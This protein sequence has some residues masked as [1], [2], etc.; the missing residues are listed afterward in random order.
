MKTIILNIAPR[1]ARSEIIDN[2]TDTIY[3]IVSSGHACIRQNVQNS[4]VESSV[5]AMYCH[6]LSALYECHAGTVY[7]CEHDVLYPIDWC[8]F[9][10][11]D[12]TLSYHGNGYIYQL[13]DG[14]MPRGNP[15]LSTLCG[16]RD[17]LIDAFTKNLSEYFTTGKIKHSEPKSYPIVMRTGTPYIDI[18]HGLNA[19]GSR[20]GK[21]TPEPP[22]EWKE[23]DFSVFDSPAV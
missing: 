8:D 5:F 23:Y 16:E 14:F 4:E 6:I 12:G 18:R 17:L 11:L 21:F 15:P 1:L 19:T 9:T 10:P 2:C 20:S 13:G 3:D 7:I 22:E